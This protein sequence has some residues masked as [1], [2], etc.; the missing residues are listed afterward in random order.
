VIATKFVFAGAIPSLPA[1]H[2][3]RARL[4]VPPRHPAPNPRISMTTETAPAHDAPQA[5][6]YRGVWLTVLLS[7]LLGFASISTDLYLPALP[8]MAASLGA[9]QGTL[10]LTVSGYLLGF[11]LG[12]L[13]WGPVSDRYGRKVPLLAGVAIFAVGAAGCALST[14]AFQ[15]IGWRIVQAL[16]ASAAVVI[17][18]AM[19]R[20]LFAREEAARV[21]STLMTIMGVA[22]LLGP[23][24]GAQILAISSWQYIFWTLV[25]I[26]LVTSLGVVRTTES[27]P[28]DRRMDAGLGSAFAHYGQHLR[29]SRLMLY[30][31]VLGCFAAGVFAYVAG[32]SFVFIQ[33]YRL[34]PDAYGLVFAAGIAGIMLANIIN[35]HLIGRFS[36]DSLMLT[37]TFVRLAA[38]LVVLG[39]VAAGSDGLVV[40]TVGL[41][42]FVAMN[43]LVGANA[44][45]GG[46]AS[47]DHGTGS[48]SALLGFAQYGGGMVGSALVGALA[49]GTPFPMA[50]IIVV[51]AVATIACAATLKYMKHPDSAQP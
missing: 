32:S 45:A 18:R 31:G 27:L 39:V 17:G 30:A 16:G 28:R 12:Q 35:R 6:H 51:S 24:L 33:Y 37:G 19:V 26:G 23:I 11:S 7:L 48:A 8:S 49:D 15:M 43:G 50:I 34:S 10:E 29:N 41:A 20:D 25:A 47:V 22:P 9:S 14:D 13:F 38:G 3:M 44:V 40:F 46:L 21:L 2:E 4:M 36:S 42:V 1:G 5:E